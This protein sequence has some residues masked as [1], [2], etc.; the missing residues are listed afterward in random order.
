MFNIIAP[1]ARVRRPLYYINEV[2]QVIETNS[3]HD[4]EVL[5]DKIGQQL[6]GGD[7]VELVGDVGAGKTTFVRGLAKGLES[8][9]IVS[10]PT[11]TVCNK[12][13]GRVVIHHCDFYRLNDD[14]LIKQELAEIISGDSVVILEWADEVSAVMPKEY[15][16]IALRTIA[17]NSREFVLEVPEGREGLRI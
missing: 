15:I 12:Y 1:F 17:E 8:S 4:T 9:D 14:T 16:K 6:K 3:A 13:Q 2:R 11:F 10:S 7:V 5:G